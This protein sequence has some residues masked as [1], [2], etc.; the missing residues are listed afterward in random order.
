MSHSH[1]PHLTSITTSQTHC[2]SARIL[3]YHINERGSPLQE[4]GDRGDHRGGDAGRPCTAA[5]ATRAAAAAASSPTPATAAVPA[6]AAPRF[7]D[8]HEA[9]R[10]EQDEEAERAEW[11]EAPHLFSADFDLARSS[12]CRLAVFCSCC[13]A[14]EYLCTSRVDLQGKEI[15]LR[16]LARIFFFFDTEY[17]T[18]RVSECSLVHYT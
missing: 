6:P 3:Q 5:E 14:Q 8:V 4:Y 2:T 10:A 1:T 15:F 12:A 17:H 13:I 7:R 16:M 9:R 18:T 11:Q